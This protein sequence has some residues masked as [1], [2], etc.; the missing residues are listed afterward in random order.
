MNPADHASRGLSAELISKPEW[1]G[2]SN[3]LSQPEESWP[4]TEQIPTEEVDCELPDE[5]AVTEVAAEVTANATITSAAASTVDQLIHHYSDWMKLKR[6]VAWWLRLQ[7]KFQRRANH[8]KLTQQRGPLTAEEM[9]NAERAIIKHVQ[10]YAFP[11]EI[12]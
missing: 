7:T 2:G 4:S 6:A 10:R 11:K 8:G 9:Q 5:Q 1:L 3:F 12:D